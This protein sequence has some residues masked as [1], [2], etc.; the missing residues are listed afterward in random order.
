[1]KDN[2]AWT[3]RKG[4][5][6]LAEIER[7]ER[8]GDV[9]TLSVHHIVYRSEAPRHENLHNPRNLIKLCNECHAWFHQQKDRRKELVIH[10]MLW[11]LFPL[12]HLKTRYD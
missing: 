5:Q 10:R 3:E 1:M 4:Y 8:C 12:L 7:C 6:A 11:D 9:N 2:R